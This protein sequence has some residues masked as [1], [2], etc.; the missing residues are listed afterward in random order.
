MTTMPTGEDATLPADVPTDLP[1]GPATAAF[2]HLDPDRDFPAL[3]GLIGDVNEHDRIDWIP[4]AGNL[5]AEWTTGPNFDPRR[6]ALLAEADGHLVGA[7]TMEWR[8]RT[9]KVVHHVEA[10]VQADVRRQGLGRA[11][12][13][14][15]VDRA[16][17][18]LAEGTGGPADLQHVIGLWVD[19]SVSAGVAFA[20]AAGYRPVRY[21]FEMRRPLDLPIPVI[22][23]PPGIEIRAMR[24]GDERVVWDA[25]VE[26]FRDHWEWAVRTEEDFVREFSHPDLDISLWQ[27]ARESD[28]VVGVVENGI[29]AHENKRLGVRI[30]WLTGVSVRRPWRRRGL[31]TALVAAS[32]RALADRGMEVAALGVD[33]ENPLGALGLYERL[34]FVR[35]RTGG[36]FR[37]PL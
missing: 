9:G 23:P 19:L 22:A 27:V 37:K 31:A 29:Y 32:L 11:L 30:G 17:T 7:S 4:T 25:G 24:P 1:I 35:H 2:R 8:E 20:E 26:A 28:E 13:R 3:A 14:W 34:G 18:S 16:R 5:A 12:E 33:S 10:W 36:Y 21:S 6:D 15:A